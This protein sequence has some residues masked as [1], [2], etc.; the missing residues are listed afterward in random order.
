MTSRFRQLATLA[1]VA[2]Y[3]TT[4]ASASICLEPRAPS[5]FMVSKPRKPY[6]ATSGSGCEKWEI[7][8]YRSEVRRHISRLEEYLADVEKYRKRAYDYAQCMAEPD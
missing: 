5:L 3:G 1:A 8:N 6:C 2:S 4:A 7:D